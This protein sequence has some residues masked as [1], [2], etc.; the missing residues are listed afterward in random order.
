[1]TFRSGVALDPT[2]LRAAEGEGTEVTLTNSVV[3][4]VDNPVDSAPE[5]CDHGM[6]TMVRCHS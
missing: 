2:V 6:M 3:F 5:S 4:Q 1:M